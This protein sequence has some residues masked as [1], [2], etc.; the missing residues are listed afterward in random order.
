MKFLAG[1]IKLALIAALAL[2]VLTFADGMH[3]HGKEQTAQTP[4]RIDRTVIIEMND[5]MRFTPPQLTATA[6]ETVR[7]V[8]RNSG[9][10]RHEMVIGSIEDLKA[11]AEMMRQM[12][13]MSHAEGNQVGVDPGQT[14]ELVWRF[15]KAGEVD[16]ACLEPGHFEAGMKGRII[17]RAHS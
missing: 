13:G 4:A 3:M 8:V 12:P 2:P 10:L 16:F 17:V 9:K 11:H 1:N 5:N 15:A 6:G 14:G 7:F